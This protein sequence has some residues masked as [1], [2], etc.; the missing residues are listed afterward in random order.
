MPIIVLENKYK[1][2]WDLFVLR[3]GNSI[4]YLLYSISKSDRLNYKVVGA[5]F[6]AMQNVQWTQLTDHPASNSNKANISINLATT[7]L[8]RG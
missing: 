1:R 8:Q 6:N 4:L 3:V 5:K 2:L 7:T